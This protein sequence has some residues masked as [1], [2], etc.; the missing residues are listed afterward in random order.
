VLQIMVA[1]GVADCAPDCHLSAAIRATLKTSRPHV[2]NRCTN[3]SH[4][5]N[6]DLPTFGQVK[7]R[8]PNTIL[9]GQGAIVRERAFADEF[10]YR[11]QLEGGGVLRRMRAECAYFAIR[12]RF[13]AGGVSGHLCGH[14]GK[15]LGIWAHLGTIATS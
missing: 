8:C 4:V 11:A 9:F 14:L 2:R 10:F 15:N 1:V 5:R 7:K 13:G 6:A 3:L 12:R